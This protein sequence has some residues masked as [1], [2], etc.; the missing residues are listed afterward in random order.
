[1]EETRIQSKVPLGSRHKK[2]GQPEKFR[3]I[4]GINR[5]D[6]GFQKWKHGRNCRESFH[7]HNRASLECA[8]DD[9]QSRRGAKTG[10]KER[11]RKREAE[12]V[13]RA[14]KNREEPRGT[15]DCPSRPKRFGLASTAS[16]TSIP[17]RD[18]LHVRIVSIPSSVPLASIQL[19]VCVCGCVEAYFV[20]CVCLSVLFDASGR[21][22]A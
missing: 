13:Q 16:W 8:E 17:F 1:M 2:K 18:H 14:E 11:G 5:I 6:G 12:R 15:E 3:H 4:K 19:W 20:W 7:A 22:S 21:S 10:E 9:S